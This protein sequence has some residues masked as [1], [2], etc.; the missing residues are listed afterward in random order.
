MDQPDPDE[1]QLGS[2]EALPEATPGVISPP[3]LN[4]Q[5]GPARTT[6]DIPTPIEIPP[7][8]ASPSPLP[9]EAASPL[10]AALAPVLIEITGRRLSQPRW[11]RTDWQ[12]G[13]ALTGYAIWTDDEGRSREVVVKMPIP[14]VERR[15]LVQLSTDEVTP[16]VFAHGRELGG[17]DLAWVVME[18]LPH[19]PIGNKWGAQGIDLLCQ[20]AANFYARAAIVPIGKPPAPRDWHGQ[21][22]RARDH[23]GKNTIENAQ[24]W[25]RTLKKAGKKLD[26]WLDL[27]NA[28]DMGTWRH[29][30]LH[31]GNAMCR[32]APPGGPAVLFD[33]ASVAPG[34]WVE[35]AVYFEHLYWHNPAGLFGYKPASLIAQYLRDYKLSPG[36]DWP[37]LADTYRALLAMT[38]PAHLSAQGGALRASAALKVLERYV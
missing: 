32:C 35:D 36:E 17:Y 29:G 34:H 20:A 10:G 22:K 3:A 13:G 1:N 33:L 7:D 15:W 30:D 24:R 27:W 19:G 25:R 5:A 9:D 18:K 21:L 16:R 8:T 28:R 14:P 23:T 38:T 4:T 11:F 31:L 37:K 2:V 12:R 26:G 6:A